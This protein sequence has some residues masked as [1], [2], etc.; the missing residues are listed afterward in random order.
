M[1]TDEQ[2]FLLEFVGLL[3]IEKVEGFDQFYDEYLK[4]KKE[5]NIIDIKTKRRK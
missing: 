5:S 3:E 2:R 1:L 4:E